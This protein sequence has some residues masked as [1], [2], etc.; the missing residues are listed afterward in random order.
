MAKLRKFCA[1]RR[2]ERPYTRISKYRNQSFVR[3]KP[4]NKIVRYNMGDPKKE[5]ELKLLLV[6][7]SELNIRHNALESARLITNRLLESSLGKGNFYFHIKLYPHHILRENPLASGAGADRMSTGMKKSFGKSI[8]RAA[9]VKK[10]QV[11]F[12]L[13]VN[14]AHFKTAREALRRAYTKLPGSCSILVKE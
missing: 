6:S 12:E 8:G 3:A 2:L 13:N 11:I 5:F 10:G 1:Y 9:R 4:A 14:K 7:K